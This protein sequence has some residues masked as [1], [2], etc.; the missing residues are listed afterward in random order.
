MAYVSQK[1]YD[2]LA[3]IDVARWDV[4]K[5]RHEG[6]LHPIAYYRPHRMRCI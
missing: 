1:L 6:A 2:R 5:H 3:N 4:L